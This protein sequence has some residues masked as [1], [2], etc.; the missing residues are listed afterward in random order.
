ME[1]QGRSGIL[2]RRFKE[3]A[4]L[5]STFRI[6][7]SP[8]RGKLS[9]QVTD[10]GAGQQRFALITPHPALRATGSPFCRYAT[11]SPGAGEICPQGVKALAP[12]Q[13]PKIDFHEHTKIGLDICA[14]TCYNIVR[15]CGHRTSASISAFQAEEV[16]S[17]PIARSIQKR[18]WF[19]Q[20]QRLSLYPGPTFGLTSDFESQK[21][22]C[23]IQ[24]EKSRAAAFQQLPGSIS[25]SIPD[26]AKEESSAFAMEIEGVFTPR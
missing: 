20:N 4:T 25:F 17:I 21:S 5:K 3:H 7:A 15:K 22:P 24:K 16:G 19:V 26:M 14:G 1:K 2:F 12:D 18:R 23:E 13:A 9:P 10:E 8:G 6:K 11:F